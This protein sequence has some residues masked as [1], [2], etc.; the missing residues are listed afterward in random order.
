LQQTGK[1][2][3]K[4]M[5]KKEME[6]MVEPLQSRLDSLSILLTI[7]EIN[8]LNIY[9]KNLIKEIKELIIM[10]GDTSILLRSRHIEPRYSL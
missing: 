4:Q 5:T 8:K 9:S 6:S 3:P 10:I 7:G 1:D 2:K